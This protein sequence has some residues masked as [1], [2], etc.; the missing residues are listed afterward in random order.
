MRAAW[1]AAVSAAGE[2][3]CANTAAATPS[4]APS[5]STA[6]STMAVRLSM[7]DWSR[8]RASICCCDDS[9][10]RLLRSRVK[11]SF[12]A[13]APCKP[14]SASASAA[15]ALSR[16]R[17]ASR[18]LSLAPSSFVRRCSSAARLGAL[19][20]FMSRRSSIR[21]ASMLNNFALLEF[22]SL[23][24]EETSERVTERQC[25][26]PLR[27]FVAAPPWPRSTAQRRVQRSKRQWAKLFPLLSP[28]PS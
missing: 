20:S 11:A 5:A 19:V 25:S 18:T 27:A 3:G 22:S 1:T 24:V 28:L 17:F 7:R 23:R 16:A 2:L 21:S 14:A 10:M 9:R 12:C 15:A 6:D 4:T 13:T 8:S 26:T